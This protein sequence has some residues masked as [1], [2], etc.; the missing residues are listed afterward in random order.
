MMVRWPTLASDRAIIRLE[1]LTFTLDATQ[2]ERNKRREM[3]M[4]A[5]KLRAAEMKRNKV[6][7]RLKK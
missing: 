7:I 3:K 2:S 5:A 1:L 4:E 6:A